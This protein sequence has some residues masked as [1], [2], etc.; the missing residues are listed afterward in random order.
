MTVELTVRDNSGLQCGI[1]TDTANVLVNHAPVVDAGPDLSTLLGAAHDV[2]QFDASSAQDP[3]GQGLA[4]S[5][6]FGDGGA[7]TGAVARHRY[8]KPGTYTVTV[9]ARDTTGLS[10]GL[11]QDTLTVTA[12]PRD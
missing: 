12:V 7:A 2:M 11:A 3:D 5:W 10:C 1:G 6:Q 8:S 9:E 4:L